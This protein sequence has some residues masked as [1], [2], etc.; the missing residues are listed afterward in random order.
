VGYRGVRTIQSAG[1]IRKN[2]QA[3]IDG[4]TMEWFTKR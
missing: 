4:Y 1:V 2:Y 3:T